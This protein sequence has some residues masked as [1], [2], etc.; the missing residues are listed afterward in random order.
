MDLYELTLSAEEAVTTYRHPDIRDWIEAID[1][2]LAATGEPGIGRDS[3]DSV[4]VSDGVLT[5]TTSYSVMNCPDSSTC[6]L[7]VTI[8][9]AAD[10]IQAAKRYKLEEAVVRAKSDL[11]DAQRLVASRA[12]N[13]EKLEAELACVRETESANA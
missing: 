1:P 12:A 8:L 2:V 7:P 11:G 5:I 6:S 10:P 4:N 9:Q 13:L 3:V